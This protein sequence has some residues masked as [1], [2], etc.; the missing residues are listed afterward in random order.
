MHRRKNIKPHIS[1]FTASHHFNTTAPSKLASFWTAGP[2][3]SYTTCKKTPYNT[4]KN[5]D[6][7]FH[8]QRKDFKRVLLTHPSDSDGNY[9]TQKVVSL[10]YCIKSSYVI[11]FKYGDL[12]KT[13]ICN[14]GHINAKMCHVVHCF[15]S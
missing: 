5:K 2:A 11:I 6:M 7:V 13:A 9:H 10:F 15:C 1:V 14:H 8:V 4:L 3:I 12:N